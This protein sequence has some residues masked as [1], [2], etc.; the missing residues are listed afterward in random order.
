MAVLVGSGRVGSGC[1][2]LGTGAVVRKIFLSGWL[3]L[4]KNN[5]ITKWAEFLQRSALGRIGTIRKYNDSKGI[6]AIYMQLDI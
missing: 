5:P 1:F 4:Y 2:G 6:V 3:W